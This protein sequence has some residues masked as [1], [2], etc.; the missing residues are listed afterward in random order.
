MLA[1][2]FGIVS[3]YTN[4]FRRGNRCQQSDLVKWDMRLAPSEL[5]EDIAINLAHLISE[6]PAIAGWF[7]V[8][9][10]TDNSHSFFQIKV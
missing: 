2:M 5:T 6:N 4:N 8:M 10:V 3:A 9:L 1:G 7:M